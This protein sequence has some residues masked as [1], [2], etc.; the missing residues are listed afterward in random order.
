MSLLLLLL[1]TDA[2]HFQSDVDQLLSIPPPFS[3]V[4]LY[5]SNMCRFFLSQSA[6]LLRLKAQPLCTLELNQV[7]ET[8]FHVK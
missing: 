6:F 8:E 5:I 1:L 3:D 7:S 4:V 2:T